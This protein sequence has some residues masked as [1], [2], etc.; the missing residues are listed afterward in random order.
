M[1]KKYFLYKVSFQ[2]KRDKIKYDKAYEKAIS[3][4]RETELKE[5]YK[6]TVTK[7]GLELAEFIKTRAYK[8][9]PEPMPTSKL[10]H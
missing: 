9:R 1:N 2:S 5:E 3:A 7:I 6:K 10:I 4:I 8:K